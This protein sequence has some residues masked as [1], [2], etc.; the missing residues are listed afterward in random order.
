MTRR[1]AMI[2]LV[3]MFLIGVSS[4]SVPAQGS[5]FTLEGITAVSV[6]V[7]KL[8]DS[9]KVIGL[10]ADAIQTD[11]ELKLRLA[12][13]HV[14]TEKE[15]LQLPGMPILYINVNLT[16]PA[17]AASIDVMFKQNVRLERN[18][19]TVANISTWDRGTLLGNP[20]AQRIRDLIKD[21][22]DVFLNDWLSVNPKK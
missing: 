3:T 22:V 14:A 10:T 12:G 13:M 18:D 4:L 5:R 17:L 19:M 7:E 11:V 2:C 1:L 15:W 20:T 9:A 8:P 16:N 6:S 21:K